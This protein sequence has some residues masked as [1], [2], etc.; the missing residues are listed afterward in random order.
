MPTSS[1]RPATLKTTLHL[2]RATLRI[3]AATPLGKA[4]QAVTS[5]YATPNSSSACLSAVQALFECK[6]NEIRTQVLP[7]TAQ[8]SP[9]HSQNYAVIAQPQTSPRPSKHRLTGQHTCSTGWQYSR[10]QLQPS[11]AFPPEEGLLRLQ[12]STPYKPTSTGFLGQILQ[13]HSTTN[14]SG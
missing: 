1:K 5:T 3:T 9:C 8:H 13:R 4:C 2:C 7:G 10:R 14:G 6:V 12:H 11:G